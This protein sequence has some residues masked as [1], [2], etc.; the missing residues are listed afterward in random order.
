M[1]KPTT[2]LQRFGD[3][4]ALLCSGH[5]PPD[6]MLHDWLTNPDS[7]A[8]QEFAIEY[9]PIW[10]QGIVVIDAARVLA[11]QPAEGEGHEDAKL[12]REDGPLPA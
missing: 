6:A 10:A 9:G 2:H 11:D 1:G 3:A 8:L 5:R 7:D 12:R 4:M